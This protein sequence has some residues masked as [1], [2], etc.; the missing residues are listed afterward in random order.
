MVYNRLGITFGLIWGV[1]MFLIMGIQDKNKEDVR[2]DALP[3][4]VCEGNNGYTV[5]DRFNYFHIFFLPLWTWG[6][7]YL[8]KCNR[9]ETYYNIKRENQHKVKSVDIDLTYWDLEPVAGHHDS[10]TIQVCRSCGAAL[11]NDFEFC[12][13]C[14]VKID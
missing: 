13:K 3:C 6:H 1:C 2:S 5:Y 10:T 11:E 12:P 4:H 7:N 14:G 8:L 9:C